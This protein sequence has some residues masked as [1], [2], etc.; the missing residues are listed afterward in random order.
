MR[1]P[2]LFVALLLLPVLAA[3]QGWP[4]YGGDAGGQRYSAGGLITRANVRL[5]APAWAFHTGE[6]PRP[7]PHG[8]SFEDAD[9]G[10][11][12]SWPARRATGWSRS[13]R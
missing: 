6:R 7:G 4:T 13:T 11:A 3:A 12:G 8:M 1:W 5:L 2:L 10:T 9:L